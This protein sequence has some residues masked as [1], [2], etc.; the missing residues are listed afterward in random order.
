MNIKNWFLMSLSSVLIGNFASASVVAYS[1]DGSEKL[2]IETTTGDT[3]FIK[4][5][6][7]TSKW[8]GKVI[9]TKKEHHTNGDR[10]SFEYF[11]DLSSGKQKRSYTPI[12]GN[13]ETLFQGSAVKKIKFYF[14]GG[15]KEGLDLKQDFA[16]TKESQKIGL[17][18]EYKKSPFEPDVD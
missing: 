4:I 11:L 1:G 13:G 9:K 7:I 17:P 3:A 10:F 12:V 18:A 5:E 16:L 8:A 14:P 2:F 6:G 15:E